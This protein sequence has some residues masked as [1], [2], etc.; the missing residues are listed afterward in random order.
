MGWKKGEEE[1]VGFNF[2]F[3]VAASF[4]KAGNNNSQSPF[5]RCKKAVKK[6]WDND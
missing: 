3:L 5:P 6:R 2:F 4:R 1:V